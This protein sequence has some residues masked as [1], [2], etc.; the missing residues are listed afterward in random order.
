MDRRRTRYHC[1]E[2]W[3]KEKSERVSA[4]RGASRRAFS[5]ASVAPPPARRDP[6]QRLPAP[7]EPPRRLS[8]ALQYPS[9]WVWEHGVGQGPQQRATPGGGGGKSRPLQWGGGSARHA[10]PL[11]ARARQPLLPPHPPPTWRGPGA[12]VPGGRP[13]RGKTAAALPPLSPLSTHCTNQA[14]NAASPMEAANATS[15]ETRA[16]GFRAALPASRVAG[17][18]VCVFVCDW[19]GCGERVV[20]GGAGRAVDGARD[21]GGGSEEKSGEGGH[22][23]DGEREARLSLPLFSRPAMFRAPRPT[24]RKGVS[25]HAHTRSTSAHP[26]S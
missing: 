17:A 19:G 15:W 6:L 26:S 8:R 20:W 22:D 16:A 21:R 13:R 3:R 24:P 2:R 4:A 5:L 10:P 18:M 1:L 14:R 9:T 11:L 12:R 23:D 7:L 25:L